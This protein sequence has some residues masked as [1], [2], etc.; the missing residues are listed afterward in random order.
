MAE[1]SR[2]IDL[3][4]M[5]REWPGSENGAT[6]PSRHAGLLFNRLPD[7]KQS[8]ETIKKRTAN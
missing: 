7:P 3:I 8:F 5:N 2:V 1:F 6:A 4:D